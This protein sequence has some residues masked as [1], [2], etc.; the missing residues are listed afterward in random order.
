[1]DAFARRTGLE[2]GFFATAPNTGDM[3]VRLKPRNQRDASVFEVINRVR[4]RIDAEAPAVRAEF[5]LIL[6]DLLGD[7]AGAPE[8]VE[9]KLFHPDVRV[10]EQAGARRG[11]TDRRRARAWRTCST[12]W[13]GTCR[14]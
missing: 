9:I 13:P 1:M 14:W 8:P 10:A 3:V 5:L 4:A 12:A 11:G 6:A 2:L 7:L